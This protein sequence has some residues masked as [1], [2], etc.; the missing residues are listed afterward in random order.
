MHWQRS[1]ATPCSV[2]VHLNLPVCFHRP[3]STV[4]LLWH[5]SASLYG[6]GIAEAA[7]PAVVSLVDV[8]VDVLVG[9]LVD[10]RV[11]M[12]V[13][14]V[15]V[16]VVVVDVMV[17]DVMVVVVVTVEVVVTVVVVLSD[18]SYILEVGHP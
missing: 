12:A 5:F 8:L 6:G 9:V 3:T 16:V 17:V 1:P 15:A 18:R 11:V 14:A 13:V 10:V 7:S 4:P 2:Q